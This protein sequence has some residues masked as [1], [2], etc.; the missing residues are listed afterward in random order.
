MA[1]D[2]FDTHGAVRRLRETGQTEE[3]AEGIVEVL[4]PFVTRDI[5]RSEL[6][7]SEA[8]LIKWMFGIVLGSLGATAALVT[9]VA[10]VVTLLG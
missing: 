2:T 7:R 6:E 9:A 3:Q 5:L 1:S 10:A 8:R 4:S